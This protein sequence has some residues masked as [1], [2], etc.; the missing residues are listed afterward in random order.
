MNKPVCVPGAEGKPLGILNN[1]YITNKP[2]QPQPVKQKD[3]NKMRTIRTKVYQFSEL[4]KAAKKKAVEVMNDIN[5]NFNWWTPIYEDA[6]EIG[7]KLDGFDFDSASFVRDLAGNFI[8]SAHE[9]AANIIRDHGEHCETNKTAQRFL[10]AGNSMELSEGEQ[11]GEGREYE[12]KM[13]ELEEVFLKELL[14]DYTKMLQQQYEHECSEEAI[15]ETI[16]ANEYEF[17]ADG[18]RF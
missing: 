13:M 18:T 12:E 1:N 3:G 14:I 10:D 2:R 8:L 4:S 7:L 16:E 11:Y 6:K 15:I 17:K 9:V 5:V